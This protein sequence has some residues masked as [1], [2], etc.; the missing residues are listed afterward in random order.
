VNYAFSLERI[1]NSTI[2]LSPYIQDQNGTSTVSAISHGIAYDR[3]D[4]FLRPSKGYKVGLNTSY[5]GL[6]GSVEYLQNILSGA[7]YHSPIEDVVFFV[8]AQAG[9]LMKI[10]KEIRAVD[11]FILGADSFRGFEYGGLGP[12]DARSGVSLGGTRYW[13]TTAEVTFP[14]GLPSEF[15]VSGAIFTDIGSVWK[16]GESKQD[17]L[18]PGTL[19]GVLYNQQRIRV[20]AGFGISWDS[21]FGPVNIDYSRTIK[22]ERHDATQALLFGFSTRY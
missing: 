22:K 20:S 10:K 6:G 14:L 21:P 7:W 15:G 9:D 17:P 12:R 19:R 1:K 2:L 8:K 3:R 5:A 11:K 4:N 13:T 16:V 18:N